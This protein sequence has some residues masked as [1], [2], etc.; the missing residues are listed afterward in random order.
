V[1][2]FIDSE[3]SDDSPRQN[4]DVLKPLDDASDSAGISVGDDSKA[5]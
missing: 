2:G 1:D 4:I 5:K 3:L